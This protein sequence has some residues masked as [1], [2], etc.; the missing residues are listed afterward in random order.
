MRDSLRVFHDELSELIGS[1]RLPAPTGSQAA[2]ELAASP[3]RTQ[4]LLTAFNQ[5]V[6]LVE[7]AAD[8]LMLFAKGLDEPVQTLAH[9]T[10]ARGVLEA[11]AFAVWLLD[12]ALSV[13]ERIGRSVRRRIQG[14]REQS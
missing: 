13:E 2:S 5:G 11:A 1:P 6:L 9:V 8:H 14:L 7:S 10:C 12:P 4:E 3:D